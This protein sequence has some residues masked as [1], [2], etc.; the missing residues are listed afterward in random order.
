MYE[1]CLN[2]NDPHYDYEKKTISKIK[3]KKKN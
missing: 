2:G 3:K 1:A